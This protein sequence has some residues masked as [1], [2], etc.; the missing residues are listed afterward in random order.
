M[1]KAKSQIT[2]KVVEEIEAADYNRIQNI[3]FILDIGEGKVVELIT[4]N[5]LLDHL[6]QAEEQDNS[7]DQ[8]LYRFRAIIGHEGLFKSN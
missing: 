6:E 1:G 2:P 8:E 3:N 5:Q 7:V 4:D